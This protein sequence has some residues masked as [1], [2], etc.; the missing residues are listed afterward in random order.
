[1][2]V[3]RKSLTLWP[4]DEWQESFGGSHSAPQVHFSHLH[5]GVHAGELD[6]PKRGDPSVVNQP[7]EP[8]KIKSSRKFSLYETNEISLEKAWLIDN[9]TR[10]LFIKTCNDD[11]QIEENPEQTLVS[12][13]NITTIKICLYC[14]TLQPQSTVRMPSSEIL[15]QQTEDFSLSKLFCL[16]F[17]FYPSWFLKAAKDTF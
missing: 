9:W 2:K 13:T 15:K 8:Y 17:S 6:F 16:I 7:P 11:N 14:P 12:W 10:K 5:V 4:P 3:R 1:M